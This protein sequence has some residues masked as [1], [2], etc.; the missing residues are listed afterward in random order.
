MSRI[1]HLKEKFIQTANDGKK[2]LYVFKYPTKAQT[3]EEVLSNTKKLSEALSK[4][5]K[6]SFDLL[7]VLEDKDIANKLEQNLSLPN[8]F[9]RTVD[10]FA[11]EDNVTGKVNDKKG[12][13]KI[14]KEFYPDFKLKKLKKFKFEQA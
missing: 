9:I 13:Q 10:F 1:K 2:N 7:L 6:N 4:I 12:W 3:F 11:P 8:L 14:F 5:V